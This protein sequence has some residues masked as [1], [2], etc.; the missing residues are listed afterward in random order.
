M[1]VAVSFRG[2]TAMRALDPQAGLR[3]DR[4]GAQAL[5]PA[6]PPSH[7]ADLCR[8]SSAYGAGIDMGR[9]L[10]DA[11]LRRRGEPGNETR[12]DAPTPS[13][14]GRREARAVRAPARPPVPPVI[15]AV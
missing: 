1:A 6:S 3:Q 10:A 14:G 2:D 4:A 12:F 5:R 7:G 15:R 11:A 13:R 9:Y 8:D